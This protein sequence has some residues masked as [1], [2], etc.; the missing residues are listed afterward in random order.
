MLNKQ[1]VQESKAEPHNLAKGR[2]FMQPA[3]A[4]PKGRSPAVG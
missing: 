1:K 2:A 3:L 4:L